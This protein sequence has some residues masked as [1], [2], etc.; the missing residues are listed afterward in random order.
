MKQVSDD[1]EPAATAQR[2][3]ESHKA[4][5]VATDLD[6]RSSGPQNLTCLRLVASVGSR[7]LYVLASVSS[8]ARDGPQVARE[9]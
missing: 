6:E 8:A 2:C 3:L 5:C 4:L 7:I 1:P 9:R